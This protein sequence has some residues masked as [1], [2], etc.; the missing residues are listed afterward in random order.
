MK[1]EGVRAK[2]HR[3]ARPASLPAHPIREEGD[4][5]P[6]LPRGKLLG[7]LGCPSRIFL[8]PLSSWGS[9]ALV[10]SAVQDEIVVWI[11]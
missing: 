2:L 11:K 1:Q 8:L 10:V 6:S 9:C 5:S 4:G 7:V 3:V